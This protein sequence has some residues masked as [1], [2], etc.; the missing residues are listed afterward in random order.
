ML[1]RTDGPL[2]RKHRESKR[3]G[4]NSGPAGRNSLCRWRE[5]P[6]G[7]SRPHSPSEA[8][9]KRRPLAFVTQRVTATLILARASPATEVHHSEPLSI[10]PRVGGS[11]TDQLQHKDVTKNT[12]HRPCVGDW[13]T[14]GY[15][16]R[17]H[18]CRVGAGQGAVLVFC[19]SSPII[20]PPTQ[21]RG[22]QNAKKR[23]L[24]ELNFSQQN[25]RFQLFAVQNEYH[26]PHGTGRG[27]V[28]PSGPEQRIAWISD[29]VR[30][31]SALKEH[32]YAVRWL[33]N[34][35]QKSLPAFPPH[36]SPLPRGKRVKL[37]NQLRGEGTIARKAI[38]PFLTA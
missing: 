12:L 32:H 1:I 27:C 9:R 16:S 28:G 33:I 36:P 10:R 7:H 5:P 29:N 17:P 2:D 3:S 30:L 15:A 23:H 8:G 22:C 20:G 14:F 34:S 24:N 35:L 37:E 18:R 38:A 26:W 13:A 6:V 31:R 19:C 21:G 25:T 11:K 4:C